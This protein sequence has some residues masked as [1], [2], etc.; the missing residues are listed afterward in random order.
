MLQYYYVKIIVFV[1]FHC[2][3]LLGDIKEYDKGIATFLERVGSLF[4]TSGV[5]P[6][7][8]YFM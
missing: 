5:V 4:I 6:T 8:A 2:V 3:L 7:Y 1:V